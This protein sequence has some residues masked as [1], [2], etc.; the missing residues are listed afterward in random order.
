ME[1]IYINGTGFGKGKIVSMDFPAGEGMTEDQI[2]YG[3]Y[4][5]SIE[6]YISGD[7]ASSSGPFEG[8]TFPDLEFLEDFSEDF[9]ITLSED[10][11]YSLN[12][13]VDITYMSGVRANGTT[14][15]PISNSKTLAFN[16]FDQTPTHFSTDLGNSYGRNSFLQL[17]DFIPKSMI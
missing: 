1:D 17:K 13:N 8:A 15:D 3:K 2:L 11:V 14:V 6:F 5:A 12:H 4:T 9:S 16:L 10:Q 7:L